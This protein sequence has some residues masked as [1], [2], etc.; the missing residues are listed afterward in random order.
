MVKSWSLKSL[1]LQR[2]QKNQGEI[3]NN[4]SFSSWFD[5]FWID[6]VKIVDGISYRQDS[7]IVC[8]GYNKY[9]SNIS[10]FPAKN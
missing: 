7:L 4:S 8:Q 2:N 9:M 3:E 10:L 6:N 5:L 1:I